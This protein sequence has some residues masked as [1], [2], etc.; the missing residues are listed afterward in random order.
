MNTLYSS[1]VPVLTN[2]SGE[3]D[4]GL[5]FVIDDDADVWRSFSLTWRGEHFVFGGYT[6]RNQITKITGCEL[7]NV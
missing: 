7:K 4:R 3:N 6:K 1:N 5:N 2:A